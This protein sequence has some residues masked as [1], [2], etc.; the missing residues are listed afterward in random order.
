MT[1]P[2]FLEKPPSFS[3]QDGERFVRLKGEVSL[4]NRG[5]FVQI[6]L[7]LAAGGKSFDASL[8]EH[9]PAETDRYRCSETNV[10]S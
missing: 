7:P 3:S 9:S 2:F 1:T 5:G 8:S 6:A 4:E 10:R